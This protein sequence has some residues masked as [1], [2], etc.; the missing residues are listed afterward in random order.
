MS[1]NKLIEKDKTAMLRKS[2]IVKKNLKLPEINNSVK[3]DLGH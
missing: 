3:V 2:A 1:D